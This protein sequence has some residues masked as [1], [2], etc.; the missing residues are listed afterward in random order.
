MT[1]G[2]A[3]GSP[4]VDTV[5]A[6]AGTGKTTTLV[7]KVRAAVVDGLAPENILVTTFTKRAAAELR[8]RIRASLIKDKRPELAAAMLGARIGTVNSVCGAL[9]ED[10]AFELGR[11]PVAEVISEDRQKALFGRAI[12]PV[13]T[14][15][16]D[17]IGPL[18]ARMGMEAQG[19]A[20]KGR[21]VEGWQDHVR[22]IVDLARS[23]GIDAAGLAESARHSVDT[24]VALLPVPEA[25]ETGDAFDAALRQAVE[26]CRDECRSRLDTL[27]IGTTKS[28]VPAVESAMEIFE[29]GED[30]P[31][32]DWAR[33][34]KLGK[35]QADLPLFTDVIAAAVVHPRHPSFRADIAQFIALQFECA[36]DC[37]AAY[38][39]Y[40]R[41]RGLVDFVD[42]EMMALAILRDPRN[43]PRLSET[44]H[45]VFV[46]EY[47]DSSPI[48]IAIFSALAQIAPVN[49]W[50]GDPKQSIYGFRDA[51]PEL[52]QA[53]ARTIT[54][55]TGGQ[56]DFLRKSWRSRPKLGA[57]VNASFEPNFL[58]VGMSSEEI[59]F[60]DYARADGPVDPLSVWE[61][62]GK[63]KGERSEHLAA[64]V[65]GLLRNPNDWMVECDVDG[66]RPARGSDIAL[67]CRSNDQVLD[68]ALALFQQ[69]VEVAVER[70]GLLDQPEIELL[71]SALRWVADP[72][73]SLAAAEIARLS[74]GET[75]WLNAAFEEDRRS[76]LKECIPFGEAL[77]EL[78]SAAPQLTPAEM[79]DS[80]IHVPGLME[81]IAAWGAMRERLANIEALRGLI[82]RYQDDQRAERQAATLAGACVW[83]G[84]LEKARQPE[85]RHAGAVN[86]LTYHGAKGLEWPICILT[87]LDSKP[88]RTPFEI[89]AEQSAPPDWRDP[90]LNRRLRYW[91]WPYGGLSA[92]LDLVAS[93][94]QSPQGMAG[95]AEERRERT[96]LL[97]VGATRARD[98]LCLATVG[99]TDWLAE[100]ANDLSEPLVHL[101]AQHILVGD[102]RFPVQAAPT[103]LPPSEFPVIAEYG[104]PAYE[105]TV[106]LP[107]RLRP[108]ETLSSGRPRIIEGV[109]IGTRIP[110]DGDPDIQA[111]GEAVHRFI[112]CDD[113]SAPPE[114]RR[115]IAEALLGNWLVP[116]LR[117]E[118]LM[119]ASENL[120]KFLT[121][122]FGDARRLRE[123]PIHAF[124]GQQFI[125]GRID[126]L[127]D[128]GEN[129][130][131]IDHKSFPGVDI[132]D[133]R[134]QAFAGQVSLYGQAVTL[135]TGRACNEYWFH[136]PIT[137]VMS[138]VVIED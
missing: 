7:G 31:W 70:E 26:A 93:A 52:T 4:R 131:I 60:D 74:G 59:T 133:D 97:Y 129:F 5:I 10:Y 75:D 89:V 122:R 25:G 136:Q 114:W 118:S 101:D 34:S 73:D 12:G 6:S 16:A 99:K 62:A 8:G 86:V 124:E 15:F 130:I 14:R 100:L 109:L 106:C 33:L 127:I 121:G 78:R 92:G 79:L 49:L 87:E 113:P 57:F 80:I 102:T 134:L 71:S 30:L 107:M 95:T 94:A 47:Q 32:A 24:L 83:L 128:T 40:K 27:K 37:L 3:S 20:G 67:L 108:S 29:R 53:A 65:A 28:D 39:S 54:E 105:P 63:N 76:A 46:D 68:I 64:R 2:S 13:I 48:Q 1:A 50:V 126:L 11:S 41:A 43:Q 112:A 137:G 44:I 119:T 116:Q 91:P 98:H 58:R 82:A 72:T 55:A 81:G 103:A 96:R 42:Q 69:G 17:R 18:A 115:Q 35:T 88:K 85:S 21:R 23:N 138:R 45:A 132:D 120:D 19:W 77:V 61:L 125:S 51:D 36:A 104:R 9:I 123:W 22:K 90:L 56:F 66:L 110:L 117:P 38:E 84:E 111:V 135:A